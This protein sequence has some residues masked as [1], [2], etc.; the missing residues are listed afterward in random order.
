G[1]PVRG[2]ALLE[3]RGCLGCHMV[4]PNAS[5]D[6]VGTYRQFGPNLAGVGSKASRDWIYGWILDPRAWSPETKMP[7][8]RLSREDALDITEY[9]STLKAPPGFDAVP[10]PKTEPA[11]LDR[12]ALYF[13]M[14][15]KTVFDA[16]AE[17]QKMDVHA[18]EV[19]AGEKLILH[20][21]CFA[22]HAIPGFE[23]AKPIGTELTEEGSKAVHR[24]DFGFVHLPHTR[25]DWF[26]SKLSNTRLFDRDRARGWEEKL[27]MPFFRFSPRELDYVTTAVLGFQKLNASSAAKKELNAD[28]VALERGRRIV[29]NH[30]C[31]G[32]HIIEGFGGSYRS[33][34]SEPSLAPPIIQGEGAKVQSNWLF[35]FLSAPKTGQIRPWLE[36]HMPTFGFTA[37]ELND[38][39]RYFA[40]LDRAR[41]PFDAGDYAADAKSW[42]AGRKVFELLKCKQCHPSS[43][44]EL[45]APGVDRS[46]L[47]PNLQMA[48]SRLRHDWIND[49]IRRPDEWMPGTR[50]PTNFPAG[51]DGRRISPLAGM[52]DAPAFAKERLE[53]G[54]IV[55]G[56]E[57]AK[58]FLSSPDAVTKALRDYVWS[59]GVNGGTAPVGAAVPPGPATVEASKPSPPA[60]LSGAGR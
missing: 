20:Y 40:V 21:G 10:L 38:L 39:T 11:T 37:E 44:R 32:C 60:R 53:F 45:N 27:R 50:M 6:L 34:V 22:C 41:Y 57:E 5:R 15:T 49:W 33:L 25:Q 1:D 26:R 55:G 31:Q 42:A 13:Q 16:K 19:Y 52:L 8:L 48:S 30:N 51:E 24:L 7:N 2:K 35:T 46:T 58:A 3:A 59:I 18:K 14:A 4:D 29:K 36:V 23:E 9:L 47:A 56:D 43:E 12:I 54:R 28:E 17:L